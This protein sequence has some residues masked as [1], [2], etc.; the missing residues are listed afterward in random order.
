MER[1]F[2]LMVIKHINKTSNHLSSSLNSL[3]T[4]KDQD[5]KR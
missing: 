3:N 2:K 1:K 4:E 5:I